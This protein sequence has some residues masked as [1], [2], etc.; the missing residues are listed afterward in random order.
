MD[1]SLKTHLSKLCWGQL[2]S[3]KGGMLVVIDRCLDVFHF[4]GF[5]SHLIMDWAQAVQWMAKLAFKRSVSAGLAV[6]PISLQDAC[7]D[8]QW[9]CFL[10][11]FTSSFLNN[12]LQSSL[13]TENATMAKSAPK[14]QR[15]CIYDFLNCFYLA[16]RIQDHTQHSL[17]IK[18]P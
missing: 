11:E 7:S 2:W 1:A 3:S 8:A 13:P 9:L 6:R 15:I 16:L 4:W 10:A 12:P 17:G 18:A 14:A 5:W